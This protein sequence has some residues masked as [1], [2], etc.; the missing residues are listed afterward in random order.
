MNRAL[1]T[2]RLGRWAR[3]FFACGT[4]ALVA[5]VAVACAT[6]DTAPA[7]PPSED[8]DGS[9]TV[10]PP[11]LEDVTSPADGGVAAVAGMV[12]LEDGALGLRR[13]FEHRYRRG[14]TA[15][16]HAHVHAANLGIRGDVYTTAGGWSDLATG[17]D[18]DL[19]R[20]VTNSGARIMFDPH[21]LVKTSARLRGRAP[22]GFADDLA[23]DNAGL[24]RGPFDEIGRP[25]SQPSAK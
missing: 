9:S 25:W 7:E 22:N 1:P 23:I 21:L 14:V 15:T 12:S 5:R 4:I 19:W 8:G 13:K 18:H 10:T 6:S 2:H 3:P 24:P 16:T 20:R 17:E 11:P